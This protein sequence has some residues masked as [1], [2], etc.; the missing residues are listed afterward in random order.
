MLKNLEFHPIPQICLT[1]ADESLR[2]LHSR[3]TTLREK[4]CLAFYGTTDQSAGESFSSFPPAKHNCGDHVLRSFAPPTTRRVADH[5]WTSWIGRQVR[6]LLM[7]TQVIWMTMIIIFDRARHMPRVLHAISPDI[8]IRRLGEFVLGR[9]TYVEHSSGS[10]SSRKYASLRYWMRI[11]L[12]N[13]IEKEYWISN[14]H[15][16]RPVRV[17]FE[18]K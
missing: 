10:G 7:T 3:W 16:G 5:Q 11:Y 6:L 9:N 2:E 4:K 13:L 1:F 15:S 18:F 14:W 8:Y 12:S 17:F